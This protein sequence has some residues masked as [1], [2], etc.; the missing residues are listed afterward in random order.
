MAKRTRSWLWLRVNS[1]VANNDL[2]GTFD[3]LWRLPEP[4]GWSETFLANQVRNLQVL[5][6]EIHLYSNLLP[7]RVRNTRIRNKYLH[8]FFLLHHHHHQ[9]LGAPQIISES[10]STNSAEHAPCMQPLE[11]LYLYREG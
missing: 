4:I 5:P 7:P 9:V 1:R 6:L 11:L 3:F 10:A 8:F 2:V